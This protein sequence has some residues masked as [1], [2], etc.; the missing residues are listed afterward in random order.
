MEQCANL[1]K[2]DLYRN[3]S[4]LSA[5]SHWDGFQVEREDRE[6]EEAIFDHNLNAHIGLIHDMINL[7]YHILGLEIPE[8]LRLLRQRIIW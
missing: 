2:A 1:K 4:L 7:G 5:F 8:K 3:L 6:I